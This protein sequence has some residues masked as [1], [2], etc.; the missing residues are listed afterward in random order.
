VRLISGHS[1]LVRAAR[2]AVELWVYRTSLL[3]DKP[4]VVVTTVYVHFQLDSYGKPQ[5]KSDRATHALLWA[6]GAVFS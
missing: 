5:T 2:Q 4:V 6:Q 1:L 3:G